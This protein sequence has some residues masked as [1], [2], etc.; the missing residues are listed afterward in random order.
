MPRQYRHPSDYWATADLL[1]TD[2]Q[3][4]VAFSSYIL[5]PPFT[6]RVSLEALLQ[7]FLGNGQ[8]F[9]RYPVELL[10]FFRWFCRDVISDVSNV[11]CNFMLYAKPTEMV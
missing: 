4:L 3:G 5:L 9:V 10:D 8:D 2:G 7:L 1:G 11:I 6:I